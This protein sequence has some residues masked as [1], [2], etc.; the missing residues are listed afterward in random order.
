[1]FS[2]TGTAILARGAF[3]VL[4]DVG[5]FGGL[6]AGHSHSD[7]LSV[8]V[9]YGDEETLIDPGTYTY[10]GDPAW[11]NRFRGSAAHNT[12]R[13]NGEDQAEA[14]NAFAWSG[15]PQVRVLKWESQPTGDLLVA[16][17]VQHNGVRHQRRVQLD[18][19]G[20]WIEDEVELP[21]GETHLVEQFWHPGVAPRM[22]ASAGRL[23]LGS[24]V[25]DF[26]SPAVL[27]EGGEAGWRSRAYGQREE[28]P[29]LRISQKC[30]GAG[31]V[32]FRAHFRSVGEADSPPADCQPPRDF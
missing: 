6:Q 24:L 25:A 26:S 27:E 16:E 30:K 13:V 29:V 1:L 15:I 5:S 23:R 7:S 4:V 14:R 32:R 2:E 10:L 11:R 9:R 22:E 28:S 20:L 17:C 8:V 18:G 12:L 3:W 19:S 21:Q 31:M